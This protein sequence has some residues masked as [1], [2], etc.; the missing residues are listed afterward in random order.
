MSLFGLAGLAEAAIA[1]EQV[2][3]FLGL[4]LCTVV[5]LVGFIFRSKVISTVGASIFAFTTFLFQPWYAFSPIPS[6]DLD[7]LSFQAGFLRLAWWWVFACCT[8]LVA[9]LWAF[10]GKPSRKKEVRNEISV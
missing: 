1:G 10:S 6:D 2:I 7:V 4:L 3:M 5:A 8:V 9:C